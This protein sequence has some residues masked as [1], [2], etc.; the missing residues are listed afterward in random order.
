[1]DLFRRI[2]FAAVLTGAV[3]GLANAGLQQWRVVP[4]IL[5]AETYESGGHAHSAE[6]SSHVY[7]DGVEV[8]HATVD[9]AAADAEPSWAPADG[10]ERIFYTT[11]ATV[12][13]GM[14]LALVV[15]AISLLVGLPLTLGNGV[16]WGLG[17]F[18]VFTL[19]P[20]FGLPPELPGM[21]AAELGARQAWW[22]GTVAATGAGVLAIAKYRNLLAVGAGLVLVLLP[23][24]IGAPA[25]SEEPSGVPAHLAAAYVATAITA[26]MVFWL[27]AGPLLGWFNQRYSEEPA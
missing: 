3:A 1:M 10:F 4:L 23:H 5:Q 22:W 9:G 13:A 19:A 8:G 26:S 14:G 21:P 24:L 12:L 17:G 27:I 7:A 16:L 18:V 6:E 15:G 2:F 11:L 25:V 20:A